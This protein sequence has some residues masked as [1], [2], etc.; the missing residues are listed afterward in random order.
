[1][2]TDGRACSACGE[3]FTGRMQLTYG[4][5]EETWKRRLLLR[6]CERCWREVRDRLAAG[7]FEMGFV[8]Q[9]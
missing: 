4:V 9:R 1:M 6:F 8:E 2:S 7:E 3:T 5:Y